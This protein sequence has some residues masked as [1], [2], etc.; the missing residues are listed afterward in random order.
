MQDRF[1]AY[2]DT[3]NESYDRLNRLL[4]LI[5]YSKGY[6]FQSIRAEIR[7][8]IRDALAKANAQ[9]I[10]DDTGLLYYLPKEEALK[11]NVQY[12]LNTN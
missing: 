8:V 1:I 5:D 2:A 9:V 6:I 4:Q 3:L 10:A 7:P 12:A 11:F